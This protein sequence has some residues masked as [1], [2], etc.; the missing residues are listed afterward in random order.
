MRS[1]NVALSRAG[2]RGGRNA[3]ANMTAAERRERAS[4]AGIAK[5]RRWRL[6]THYFDVRAIRESPWGPVEQV[7]L[8]R[9]SGRKMGWREVWE[10]LALHRPGCWALQVF[11]D[12][13][14]LIDEV[15]CYHLWV[16]PAGVVPEPL[17]INERRKRKRTT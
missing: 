8:G 15:D 16:L 12:A 11:P 2:Q 9:H 14:H 5:M 13:E 6:K 10:V 17:T 7:Q 4:K 1:F 3:A